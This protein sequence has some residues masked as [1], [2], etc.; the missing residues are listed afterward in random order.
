MLGNVSKWLRILGYETLF[1]KR[2]SD[3]TLIKL[4]RENN[5]ILLTSDEELFK[6][7]KS[8]GV[9][10]IFVNSNLSLKEKLVKVFKESNLKP[11][12][13]STRC[14]VCGGELSKIE[15]KELREFFFT[16][17]FWVCKKCGKLYWRGSHWKNIMKMYDELRKEL[18][19]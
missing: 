7:A 13:N 10:V 6:K 2:P 9:A 19:D 11:Q 1:L 18:S 16:S 12:L 15:M 17:D 8:I 4:S 14:T 5:G 3:E